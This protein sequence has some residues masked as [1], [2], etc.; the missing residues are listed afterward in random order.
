MPV[1]TT[2]VGDVR[3]VIVHGENGFILLAIYFLRSSPDPVS[4]PG[5]I[6][7][8]LSGPALRILFDSGTKFE[9]ATIGAMEQCVGCICLTP[10]TFITASKSSKIAS[11]LGIKFLLSS[12]L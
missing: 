5:C 10:S 1:V 8:Q 7:I 3:E 11:V 2:D 12:N 6:P 4:R 9:S